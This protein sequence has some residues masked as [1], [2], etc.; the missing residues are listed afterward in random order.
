MQ[1]EACLESPSDNGVFTRPMIFALGST[2][3]SMTDVGKIRSIYRVIYEW[4]V[5]RSTMPICK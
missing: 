3:I 1:R 5:D 2:G 4:V